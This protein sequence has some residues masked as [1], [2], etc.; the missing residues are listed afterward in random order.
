MPSVP[1]RHLYDVFQP[2]QPPDFTQ[3]VRNMSPQPQLEIMLRHCLGARAP[4]P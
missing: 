2:W 3:N 4:L 1:H